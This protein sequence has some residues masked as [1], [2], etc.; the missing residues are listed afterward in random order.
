MLIRHNMYVEKGVYT[1]ARGITLQAVNLFP[2][3]FH[4]ATSPEI[5]QR[6]VLK[7]DNLLIVSSVRV[8]CKFIIAGLVISFRFL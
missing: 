4:P 1:H 2:V 7:P 3:F 5:H 6:E 8:T